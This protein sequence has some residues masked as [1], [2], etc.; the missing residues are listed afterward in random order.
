METAQLLA[1]LKFL[2]L[3]VVLS[4]F[5]QAHD[6][7]HEDQEPIAGPLNS[8]WYNR[9]PGEGGTQV[10]LILLIYSIRSAKSSRPTPYSAGL[11][12]SDDYRIIHALQ[13]TM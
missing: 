6:D 1:M 11:Q 9:L 8:L 4:A 5:A 10:H 13:T 2:V 3:A 12:P 7:G